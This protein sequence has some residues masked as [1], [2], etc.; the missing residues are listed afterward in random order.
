VTKQPPVANFTANRT[1][2]YA[3]LTVQFTDLSEN[4]TSVSWDFDNNELLIPQQVNP[5]YEFI[6]AGIYTVNLTATNVNGTDSKLATINVTER[7][8]FFL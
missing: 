7:E 4:A 6:N 2:G 1:E 8:Q 5:V 3:P